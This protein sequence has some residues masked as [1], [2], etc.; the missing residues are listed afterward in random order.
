MSKFK[1]YRRKEMAEL[2][3]YEEG[4][5]L[6]ERVSVSKSDKEN[7]S[8][9]K[10]DMIARNP[11]NHDDI[12][13]VAEKYFK[14]NFEPIQ[15]NGEY[16]FGMAVTL[17]KEGKKITRAGWNGKGMFVYHVPKNR[18]P[19]Q[20]EAAKSHFGKNSMVPYN[21]YLAI[22]N[23]DNTVSTWVPSIND[24]LANDWMVV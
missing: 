17:V 15:K 12:R 7:G 5:V 9:K 4:T 23:V 11:K 6:S 1:Q 19:V 16:D 18:Y 20:T 22:K 14:D 21:D 8:P 13:L 2:R 3:E 24:C 10:G